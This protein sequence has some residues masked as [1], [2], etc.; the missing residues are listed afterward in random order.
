M[1]KMT[2]FSIA[3]CFTL[4]TTAQISV[5]GVVINDSIPLESASVI[6]KNSL[7]GVATNNKGEF[8]LEAKKG[9]TLSVSYLGYNLKSLL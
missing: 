2:L 3:V 5:S 4:I 1:K 9:D 6:I 7:K 8:K